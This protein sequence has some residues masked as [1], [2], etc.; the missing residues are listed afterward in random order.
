MDRSSF[1]RGLLDD[2]SDPQLPQYDPQGGWNTAKWL[3]QRGAALTGPGGV[4]D[5][6][7]LLGE[8]SALAQWQGGDRLGGLLTAAGVIP[9]VGAL[10]AM[11]L[12]PKAAG[13]ASKVA[14]AS[15]AAAK[16]ERDAAQLAKVRA[17]N[18][19]EGL[20]GSSGNVIST[21][22]GLDNF[23]PEFARQRDP[24]M[25]HYSLS[26]DKLSR[27]VGEFFATHIPTGGYADR[28][29]IDPQWFDGKNASL[30]MA[31][32]DRSAG[33]LLLTSVNGHD[34]TN[35]ALLEAGHDYMRGPAANSADRSAWASGDEVIGGLANKTRAEAAAGFDPYLAYSAMGGTSVDFSHHMTDPLLDL[36]RTSPVTKR[37][38]AEF[39]RQMRER[40]TKE[41]AAHPDWPGLL[42]PDAEEYLWGAGGSGARKKLAQLANKEEWQSLGMPDVP[43]IRFGTMDLGL[44]NTAPYA[45]GRSITKLDPAGRKIINPIV[46]HNTYPVGLGADPNVGYVGGFRHDIPLYVA[47]KEWVDKALA[48]RPE[49]ADN[50]SQLIRKFTMAGP[51][52]RMTPQV[53]DRMSKYGEDVD[54]GRI[55]PPTADASVLWGSPYLK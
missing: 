31:P 40:T 33:G 17:L 34:L 28:K 42:S 48:K 4:A 22:G 29:V 8:P 50:T 25:F 10:K 47:H 1:I 41:W 5:A 53:I 6:F 45:I 51:P 24:R 43:G 32:G 14:K 27:P 2:Q 52:I 18:A 49:L 23:T 7:G 38:M 16:A 35:P 3:G 11:A 54:R 46:P 39:D 19:Q 26:P 20:L 13:A 37:D 9:G 12:A 30:I 44:L 21:S 15:A 36:A 55:M